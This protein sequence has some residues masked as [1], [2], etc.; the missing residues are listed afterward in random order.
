MKRTRKIIFALALP[1]FVTAIA[2]AQLY[3]YSQNFNSLPS[4]GASAAI[5]G[6]GPLTNQG[7]LTSI[8]AVDASWQAARITGTQIVTPVNLTV[9]TG[10]ANAGAIYS[11]GT[12]A[13]SNRSL[14]ELAS[15]TT[16]PA[17]GVALTNHTGST[18]T[19][20]T[21][22]FQGEQWRSPSGTNAPANTLKF[23]YGFSPTGMTNSNFLSSALMTDEAAGNVVS[24]PGSGTSATVGLVLLDPN[25]ITLSGITW[26][27]GDVFYMR[28]QDTNDAA[29]DAGLAIDDLVVTAD[30]EMTGC[31]GDL[32]GS[33]E[34]DSGDLGL[35]LLDFGPCPGCAADLDGS[36]EVDSGDL[37]LLLLSFGPC[38]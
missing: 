33:N 7:A 6:T 20:I 22:T 16:I 26:N 32:D 35:M 23:A 4:S 31:F 29:N 8:S 24:G 37:G 9:D 11:Y 17:F 13:S 21:I 28:W 15:G 2:S 34:V 3:T 1:L 30:I 10:A 38:S 19:T 12:T 18:L 25:T 27:T 14:G 36:N 5:T